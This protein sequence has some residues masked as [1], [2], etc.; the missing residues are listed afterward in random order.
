[1]FKLCCDCDDDGCPLNSKEDC[2]MC[3]IMCCMPW[4]VT[5]SNP[6]TRS[7]ALHSISAS[8]PFD[9]IVHSL[10]CGKACCGEECVQKYMNDYKCLHCCEN[11]KTKKK[12]VSPDPGAPQ[13]SEMER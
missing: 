13:I 10:V 8:H 4:C 7:Q 3:H 1:M 5:A 6:S 12:K 2:Y 9:V 11:A